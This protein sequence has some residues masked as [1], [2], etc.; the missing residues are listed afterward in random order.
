MMYGTCFSPVCRNRAAC[1]AVCGRARAPLTRRLARLVDGPLS[2]TPWWPCVAPMPRSPRPTPSEE[3]TLGGRPKVINDQG[4]KTVTRRPR[5]ASLGIHA[6]ACG[7][8][9]GQWPEP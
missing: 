1:A 2:A 5:P 9:Y 3:I 4:S 7:M 6:R 8:G